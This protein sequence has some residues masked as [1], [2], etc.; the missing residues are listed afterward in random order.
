MNIENQDIEQMRKAWI[1]MG[2]A[3]GM[4]PAPF[5]DPGEMG[6][7]KTALD[8]L[9]NRYRVFWIASL[10]L[11][12][13]TFMFFSSRS[14]MD[15]RLYLWLGIAYAVYFLTA[16]CMDFWL[17]N[18]LG[19]INPLKMGVTEVAWKS[20]F[21][22]KRH[23]QFMVVLIPMA[24]ALIAFTGYVFSSEM[25]FLNGL[26]TGVILGLIIGIIQLRRFMTEYRNLSE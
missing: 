17:Y 21:Y 23:L 8:R 5:N 4:Q 2:K 15:G 11:S 3:L 13:G 14:I 6:S 22:R 7:K 18:G 10:L 16:F 24:I 25:Y 1:E 26:A 9:R 20:A 12:F 19:T